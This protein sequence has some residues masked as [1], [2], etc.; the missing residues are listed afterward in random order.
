MGVVERSAPKV[1]LLVLSLGHQAS[2]G[3]Q[4]TPG[5]LGLRLGEGQKLW[6]PLKALLWGVGGPLVVS[7][8]VLVVNRVP[9]SC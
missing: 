8:P 6:V 4:E 1:F 3:Y 7:Q 9:T 5:K 2:A